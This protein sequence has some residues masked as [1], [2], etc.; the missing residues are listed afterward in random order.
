MKLLTQGDDFGFTKA[1][2]YGIIDA[3][4]HGVLRNTGLFTNMPDAVMAAAYIRNN[5]RACFGIDFNIVSGHPVSDPKD[6][7]ALVDENGEFIRSGV[8][9]KDP[10][11]QSES[12]R[13]E[14]FPY[15]QVYHELKAQY[16]R[17]LLLTGKK[18]GY[19]HPHS[20]MPENYVKAI[21]A[22][23]EETGIVFSMDITE[24]LDF[25]HPYDL[26][27]VSPIAAKKVFDP[28]AQL[29]KDPLGKVQKVH[30]YLENAEYVM[31]GGHPG[32]V[33]SDLLGLTTLSLERVRDHQ[34]MVSD[35]M[36]QWIKENKIELITYYDLTKV[37]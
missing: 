8:R 20:I 3:I 18:P 7:P 30:E 21:R 36:K 6:I 12:G 4:E 27:E 11:W 34:M 10:R 35:W 26:D 31:I 5:D 14:Q 16:D 24:K 23:S 9:Q 1:V 25:K 22:L 19:L 37:A 28:N 33:D 32:F 15:D 17:F 13:A 29:N 2:T